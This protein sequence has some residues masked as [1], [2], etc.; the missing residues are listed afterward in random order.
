MSELLARSSVCLILIMLSLAYNAAVQSS[1]NQTQ[2]AGVSVHF[3]FNYKIRNKLNFKFNSTRDLS[4]VGGVIKE[5][6]N[7]FQRSSK[8][9]FHLPCLFELE[10]FVVGEQCMRL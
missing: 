6:K 2:Q 10:F 5:Q 3:L 8:L 4:L 1:A 7:N 9:A